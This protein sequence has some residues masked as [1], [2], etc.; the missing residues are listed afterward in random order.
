MSV[1]RLPSLPASAG[2]QHW[3]NLPGAALSLAVAEAA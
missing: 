3:G 1:L 2:K